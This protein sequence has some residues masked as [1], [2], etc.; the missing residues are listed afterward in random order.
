MQQIFFSSVIF[1]FKQMK[2]SVGG[3]D[4]AMQYP[5]MIII[6]AM[7]LFLGACTPMADPAAVVPL[8]TSVLPTVA[9]RVVYVTPTHEPSPIATVAL[10]T[11]SAIP[12][13]TPEMTKTPDF[14]E[15]QAQCSTILTSLYATASEF[16]LGEPNG[17]FCNGG[18]PPRA[19][20][21]G[22]VNT[23]LGV[24]GSL[25]EVGVVES[26]HTPPLLSNN[27]GGLMWVRIAEPLEITALLLGDV[28][29]KDVTPSDGNLPQWQSISV[30]TKQNET[31]CASVPYSMFVAQGP[32]G[33]TTRVVIN[34]ISIDLR[35]SI[36]V[37]THGIETVFMVLEGE[38]HLTIFGQARRLF[39]GQQLNVVY[40][41]G[42]FI[43][44]S[45]VPGEAVPLTFEYIRNLPITLLDRPVLLP[46]PGYVYTNT[47][48]NIREAPSM[49]AE[50]LFS[51]VPANLT[52][53]ILGMNVEKIWYHV[54]L[55][56]GETGWIREDLVSGEVGEITA[57]YDAEPA[58]PERFGDSAHK[59][60]VIATSGANLRQAPDVQF[61]VLDTLE[62]GTEVEILARSP[63][64]PFVKVDTGSQIGWMA[65]ITLET[66]TVI[67]FLPVDNDVP[68][69]PGPTATPVFV[70]GGGHAYP[71]PHAGQ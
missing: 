69:P 26:V 24:Q 57:L 41:N 10:A 28:E 30:V 1:L 2:F 64:S 8:D 46:Q 70:Y 44:P 9:A 52:L 62:E 68:L 3:S 17:Y 34:G 36:A 51:N 25:V 14:A 66:T 19:Q 5:Y 4:T 18:L 22:V 27:S 58:P 38:S 48:V 32:W 11:P 60:T 13:N 45:E 49:E 61:P 67:Q 53:S 63:Y 56:N 40:G 71:D 6:L 50:K 21:S 23:T 55:P 33:Q 39:A 12:G 47:V 54:R 65:L 29:L 42:D 16:C 31:N 59:G 37:Q 43:R 20:P 7:S 35:G 15:V